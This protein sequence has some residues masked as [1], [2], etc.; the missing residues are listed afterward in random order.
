VQ[1][2]IVLDRSTPPYH[3]AQWARATQ[4]VEQAIIAK[5]SGSQLQWALLSEYFCDST[6]CISAKFAQ[7][8]L[9]AAMFEAPHRIIY[10]VRM[11]VSK[12]L[13]VCVCVC[14]VC[15][16]VFISYMNSS[17]FLNGHMLGNRPYGYTTFEYELTPY[18]HAGN[19]TIAVKV[20]NLGRNSRYY[21]GSGIYR[22]TY[23]TSSL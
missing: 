19:N 14:G 22:H 5:H 15:V 23:A 4:L 6:E 18:L 2:Q 21:S 3:P 7:F 20:E 9:L 11:Y 17:V 10:R 16:C 12:S 8:C 1:Q 13:L